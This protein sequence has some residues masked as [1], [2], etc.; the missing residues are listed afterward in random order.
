VSWNVVLSSNV[1][2]NHFI[3]DQASETIDDDEDI[4]RREDEQELG[5]IGRVVRRLEGVRDAGREVPEV[6]F[7]LQSQSISILT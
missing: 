3:N 2:Y 7:F 6:T 5:T 4:P 1:L